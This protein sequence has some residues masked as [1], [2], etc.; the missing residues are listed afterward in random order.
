DASLALRN[1]LAVRDVLRSDPELRR[2]YG[3]LKLDLASRDIADSDA[4]VAAK[5]PVLQEV[6]HASGR[7]SPTEFATIEALN[8]APDAG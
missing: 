2:R 1:H 8:N 3:E 7:F 4:Y 6:L 5:S